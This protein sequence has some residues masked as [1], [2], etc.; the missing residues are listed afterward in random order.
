MKRVIGKKATTVYNSIYTLYLFVFCICILTLS[1][2]VRFVP[3][4]YML[5][6]ARGGGGGGRTTR[7]AL[8]FSLK[9]I[10][11][12]II[13]IIIIIICKAKWFGHPHVPKTALF[14][15]AVAI[16]SLKLCLF[17]RRSTPRLSNNKVL[18]NSMSYKYVT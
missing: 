13:I 4:L 8:P 14:L 3:S 2:N 16:S 7:H 18:L 12:F 17:Y 11:L 1:I 10:N 6:F 5:C 15:R 9:E